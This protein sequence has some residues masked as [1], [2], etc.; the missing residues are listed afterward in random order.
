M[1]ADMANISPAF[2]T[3]FDVMVK[4]A[5]QGM[6]SL[7]GTC[8]ERMNVEGTTHK[9][10]KIAQGAASQRIPQ[11]DVTPINAAYSTVSVTL[12]DWNAAEYSDV[13]NQAKVNFDD[14]RE[15]SQVVG[16]AIGRRIDQMKIDA[17]EAASSSLT[18][19]DT[20]VTTGSA[21]AS[22]LNVGKV[23]EAARLLDAN[24]VP[25]EDRIFLAHAN[26]KA[27]LLGDERA[28]SAD[29]HAARALASGQVDTFM[30]FKFVFI[31]DRDE[32]GLAVPGA[33][34]RRNFA[35]HKSALGY[36]QGLLKTE[37]NYVPEKTSFLVN[38]CLAANAVAIDAT[39][40]VEITCDES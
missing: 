3:T 24:N 11:T 6:Q 22:N 35:F 8:R 32:G 10:P 26:S 30:G 1:E 37:I 39:G 25:A 19:A 36:A 27:G 14:V 33:S 20:I 17:L 9:F 29:Y 12:E 18:V 31:G 34:K 2:V 40:I 15:L 16:N 23:I 21:T 28:V 7:A 13:F 4:Q 5:F 38:S